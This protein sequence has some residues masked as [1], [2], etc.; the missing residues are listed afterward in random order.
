ME[1]NIENQNFVDFGDQGKMPK[2]GNGNGYGLLW[3]VDIE[4]GQTIILVPVIE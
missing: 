1:W 4:L 2:K 3:F